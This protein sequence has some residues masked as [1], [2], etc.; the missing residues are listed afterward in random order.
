M[1]EPQ[2]QVVT[3]PS[4]EQLH[5]VEQGLYD[6]DLECLGEAV[7]RRSEIDAILA[8]DEAGGTIG[9]IVGALAYDWLHITTFWVDKH[10]RGQGIGTRLLKMLEETAVQKEVY[11]CQLETTSFQALD[12]YLKNGYEIF[13]SLEG[14]PVG[15]TWYYLKKDL[16][17]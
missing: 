8:R 7:I 1:S 4:K 6:Y 12:F 15:S 5:P 9:G 16:G 11:K 2:Y 10:Y 3:N 17:A 14:K 13:G